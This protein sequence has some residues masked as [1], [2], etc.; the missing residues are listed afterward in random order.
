MWRNL[1]WSFASVMA[2]I[3]GVANAVL[4]WWFVMNEA[5]WPYIIFELIPGVL[6]LLFGVYA[7]HR[8]GSKVAWVGLLLALSPLITWL[9]L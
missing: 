8:S 5:M 3:C 7:I 6:G 1:G 2:L 9:S 4:H